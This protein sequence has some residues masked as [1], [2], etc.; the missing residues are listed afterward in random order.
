MSKINVE[1]WPKKTRRSRDFVKQQ[2]KQK[3][4]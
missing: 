2:G 4:H 1:I 3:V